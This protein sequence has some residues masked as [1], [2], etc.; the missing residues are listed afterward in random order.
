MP[1]F[2]YP[3]PWWVVQP[4]EV[5]LVANTALTLRSA[6]T[7]SY[8]DF[9]QQILIAVAKNQTTEIAKSIGKRFTGHLAIEGVL[10]KS[11]ISSWDLK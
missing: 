9:A 11:S 10:I 5:P 4:S 8:E 2:Q 1:R 3:I 6:L 7:T